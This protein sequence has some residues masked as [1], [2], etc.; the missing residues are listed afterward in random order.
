M[1]SSNT[2]SSENK[3]EIINMQIV[4]ESQ[5]DLEDSLDR[6]DRVDE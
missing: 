5:N 4:K 3:V 2:D 6:T 1:Y